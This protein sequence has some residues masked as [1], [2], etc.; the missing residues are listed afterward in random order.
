MLALTG[1]NQSAVPCSE[2]LNAMNNMLSEASPCLKPAAV[3]WLS[4]MELSPAHCALL[5]EY[6]LLTT[7]LARAA[8]LRDRS[9]RFGHVY[10][11]AIGGDGADFGAQFQK[12]AQDMRTTPSKCMVVVT[13]KTQLRA[14]QRAGMAAMWSH[15]QTLH[16]PKET[17]LKTAA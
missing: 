11:D 2:P 3:A 9:T 1:A 4:T 13:A 7:N 8:V 15:R 6:P 10:P 16:A 12:V 17:M 5:S 14:A